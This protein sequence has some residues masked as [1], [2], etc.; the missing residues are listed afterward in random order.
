ML[1]AFLTSQS[2]RAHTDA[3]HLDRLKEK[4]TDE[5]IATH[6]DQVD[7][8][9]SEFKDHGVV[10]SSN[11]APEIIEGVNDDEDGQ[12]EEGGEWVWIPLAKEALEEVLEELGV[13]E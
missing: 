7:G 12:A 8:F 1:R 13:E 2:G 11:Q 10:R 4:A 9:L 6:P 3:S 5:L